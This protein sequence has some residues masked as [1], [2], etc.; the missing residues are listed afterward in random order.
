MAWPHSTKDGIILSNAEGGASQPMAVYGAQSNISTSCGYTQ[1]KMDGS[2]SYFVVYSVPN[3][4]C[5]PTADSTKTAIVDSHHTTKF[6]FTA[7]STQGF[8]RDGI[9]IF[10]HYFFCG[11]AKTYA[12]S[13]PNITADFTPSTIPG[14][15]SIIITEGWWSLYTGE[16]Y[17]NIVTFNGGQRFGP[18]TRIT[19]L[20]SF[21]DKV[22]S[23]KC[24][25]TPTGN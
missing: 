4:N 13:C 10:E 24:F 11:N 8:N 7:Q 12:S 2:D 25:T 5:Q 9:T 20:Q 21:N 18:G 17:C 23:I 15:S 6:G 16:N 14:A 3:Y 19:G 1:G 22:K